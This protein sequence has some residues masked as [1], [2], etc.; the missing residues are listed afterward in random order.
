[1]KEQ[2]REVNEKTQEWLAKLSETENK[3]QQR[4]QEL[5]HAQDTI[6]TLQVNFKN[7]LQLKKKIKHN[8][9]KS[10]ITESNRKCE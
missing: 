6:D 1:M 8:C 5:R 3:L 4:T 10:L 9:I 2:L 7:N